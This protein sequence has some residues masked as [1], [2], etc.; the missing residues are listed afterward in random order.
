MEASV[1]TVEAQVERQHWWFRGRRRILN[2]LLG[3]VLG[4]GPLPLRALDVGCG[5]GILA[6][7][8][9]LS[10]VARERNVLAPSYS[11]IGK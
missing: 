1:Y 11:H 9:A 7:I 5:T 4:D 2:Q 10:P 3:A 6:V 8:A